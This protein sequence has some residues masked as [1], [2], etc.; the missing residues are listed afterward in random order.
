ML[1]QSVACWL[2]KVNSLKAGWAWYL[3]LTG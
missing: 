3:I 1:M 2:M